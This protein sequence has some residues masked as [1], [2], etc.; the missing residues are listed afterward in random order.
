MGYLGDR[1]RRKTVIVGSLAFWSA[2]TLATGFAKGFH[3]LV[4]ALA[5]LGV[6]EAAYLPA[7][8]ALIADHHG[9]R[10]RSLATGLHMSGAYC[11]MVL[12]GIVAGWLGER[13]GWRLAFTVLGCVGIGYALVV[14]MVLRGSSE[15][16]A[17]ESSPSQVNKPRLGESLRRVCSLRAFPTLTFVFVVM[18]MANWLMYTW[19]PAYLYERFHMSLLGAGFSATFYLQIGSLCGMLLGGML[20]DRWRARTRRGRLLTQAVSLAFA[21]PFLCLVGMTGSAGIFLAAMVVYGIGRGGYD[22]NIMPVLCEIAP[23]ELRATGYGLFNCAGTVAGGVVAALAGA[24][25]SSVGLGGMMTATGLLLLVS[26]V[27]FFRL[28][29]PGYVQSVSVGNSEV[30]KIQ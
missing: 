1:L 14:A 7:G 30:M 3:S 13:Y 24:L 8:L 16:P 27:L 11:G 9:E 21:A 5:L 2:V 28:Q 26:A 18:S 19:M 15:K 29:L 6:A 22:S 4:L 23:P 12:G 25:K 10:T 17:P 20:A